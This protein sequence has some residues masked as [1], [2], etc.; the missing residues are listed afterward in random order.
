MEAEKTEEITC[1]VKVPYIKPDHVS[2]GQCV[3]HQEF[4]RKYASIKDADI[5]SLLHDGYKFNGFKEIMI[6]SSEQEGF[7]NMHHILLL[8][9]TEGDIS[10]ELCLRR[11]NKIDV[12]VSKLKEERE[13]LTDI[14]T[15]VVMMPDKEASLHFYFFGYEKK[16]LTYQMEYPKSD[17]NASLISDVLTLEFECNIQVINFR[18]DAPTIH[19]VDKKPDEVLATS[20]EMIVSSKK[21]DE[22]PQLFCDYLHETR[23][24]TLLVTHDILC[25]FTESKIITI[26]HNNVTWICANHEKITVYNVDKDNSLTLNHTTCIKTFFPDADLFTFVDLCFCNTTLQC[27]VLYLKEF[28]D[29]VSSFIVVLDTKKLEVTSILEMEMTMNRTPE[30]VMYPLRDGTRLFVQEFFGNRVIFYQS[31]TLL[32]VDHMMQNLNL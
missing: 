24:E 2:L 18:G 19:Y 21:A 6:E 25:E 31:F 3:V 17:F 7:A 13:I 32:P 29:D 16:N 27:F 1:K 5:H 14:N 8:T 28:G 20:M 4:T 26:P 11:G 22:L 23:L 10:K 30:L 15:V 9:S 12:D